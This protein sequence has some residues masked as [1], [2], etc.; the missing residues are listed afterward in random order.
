MTSTTIA[1]LIY[2][3]ATKIFE[4]RPLVQRLNHLFVQKHSPSEHVIVNESMI[5]FKGR[6]ALKQ[7]NSMKPIRRDINCGA[8]QTI[9][10]LLTN[11]KCTQVK[12]LGKEL[13]SKSWF[14]RQCC[15]QLTDWLQGKYHKVIFDIFFSS[16][17]LLKELE[18]KSILAYRTIRPNRKD[19]PVIA[20]EKSLERDDFDFRCTSD[21]L[22]RYK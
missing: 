10:V 21:R 16:V 3:K 11:L 7:Y 9:M 5:C 12:Y 4:I 15:Y 18:R 13:R 22:S 20:D 6:T 14:D 17:S 8:L 2:R 19:L 1:K